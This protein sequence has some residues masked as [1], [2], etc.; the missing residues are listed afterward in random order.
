MAGA[1]R[2]GSVALTLGWLVSL[3][4]CTPSGGAGGAPAR[5]PTAASAPAAGAPSAAPSAAAAASPGAAGVPAALLEGA[6][7]ESSLSLV[8]GEGSGGG[9]EGARRLAS[10]F[11]RYY[12][13]NLDVRFTPGPSMPEMAAKVTQE[14]QGG[15][16]ATTDIFT[17]YGGWMPVMLEAGA[18]EPVE[19]ASIAP[20][21][22]DPKLVAAGGAGVTVQSSLQGITYNTNR[23]APSEVP[24]SLQDLLDARYEGRV[25]STPYA[26]GFDRLPVP[27]L[28][29]EQRTL[30]FISRFAD[31]LA[32]LIRCN[33]TSRV[34]SGEFD[35]F[36]LDCSQDNALTAKAQGAPIEFTMAADAPFVQLLY[37]AVPRNAAHPNAAKLW[38][39]YV[40]TR[41]AQDILYEVSHQDSHLIAGSHTASDMERFQPPGTTPLIIG[42][43]FYEQHDE[44]ELSRI[45]T[46]IERRLAKK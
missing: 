16:T 14:F 15:R 38:I 22:Q 32:G 28:W 46:E 37:M 24:H 30:D 6:R 27:E 2:W 19:W 34:A 43:D 29:G 41:E 3:V 7:R 39:N 35:I 12:G 44:K 10:G 17:G 23:V 33:E 4:A 21:V 20:N 18:L 9:S 42:V 11:N 40:A 25:A 5:A 26:S 31:Q 13:L 8:W 36:A 1:R 45:R